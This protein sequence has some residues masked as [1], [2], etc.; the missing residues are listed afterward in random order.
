MQRIKNPKHFLQ[1]WKSFGSSHPIYMEYVP[2]T[3]K[4]WIRVGTKPV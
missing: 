3:L 4:E 1:Y 2:K